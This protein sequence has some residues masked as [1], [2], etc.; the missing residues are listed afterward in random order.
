MNQL[1]GS[2]Q[3]PLTA[4]DLLSRGP[5]RRL[6]GELF[7]LDEI[8]STNDFLRSRV[9][10]TTDGAIACAEHQSA[11]RGRQGRRWDAP[12]GSSVLLS[13]LLLESSDSPLLTQA[14]ML[15]SLAACEAVALASTCEPAV[16]WP[17]DIVLGGRKLGGV[18]AESFTLPPAERRASLQRALVIGV[19]INCLQHAGHFQVAL[20]ERATSI[21]L[22][23]QR[24]VDRAAVAGRLVERLDARLAA[25]AEPDGPARLVSTWKS[26]CID[27]GTHAVLRQDADEFAGTVVDIDDHGDL[28]VQLDQGGRRHFASATTTRAG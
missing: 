15:A 24:P 17:N 28:I 23:S 18:L 25:H 8:D 7:L 4:G 3:R 26:R 6:G 9:G 21:D 1:D 19:G 2:K 14:A 10:Q 12:R 16:R 20:A 5:L 22:E 13:V 27:I 11:G